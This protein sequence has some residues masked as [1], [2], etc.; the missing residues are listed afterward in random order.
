MV[1]GNLKLMYIGLVQGSRSWRNVGS[2]SAPIFEVAVENPAGARAAK[3]GGAHRLELAQALHTTGGITPSWAVTKAVCE[4]GLPVHVLIR[5]RPGGFVYSDEEIQIMADDIAKL[6]ELPVAGFVIGA[7]TDQGHLDL[8]AIDRLVAAAAGKDITVHRVIDTLA[9]PL[10]EV[11]K[12][13]GRVKRILTS[14]GA[15]SAD[16][17]VDLLRQYAQLDLEVMAGGG[18]RP[19]NLAALKDIG[20]DAVHSSCAAQLH[21]YGSAGPGGG[22]DEVMDT[23]V[24]QVKEIAE[25]V[26]SWG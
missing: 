24:A 14:G 10:P 21:A 6:A 18:V 4:V 16:Q 1:P 2:M 3:E 17:G 23:D 25:V 11:E 9:E 5:C 26:S 8:D 7:A 12:L 15:A 19:H 20:V 13:V 22:E